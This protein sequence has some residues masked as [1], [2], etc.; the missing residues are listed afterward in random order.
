[1]TNHSRPSLSPLAGITPGY[2]RVVN[3]ER[4]AISSDAWSNLSDLAT[5]TS[6]FLYSPSTM[7][8]NN[9]IPLPPPASRAFIPS[10]Y[11]QL[12]VNSMAGINRA[13]FCSFSDHFASS[14]HN[15]SPVQLPGVSWADNF[16]SAQQAST[17]LIPSGSSSSSPLPFNILPV[18][19]RSGLSSKKTVDFLPRVHRC[20][21]CGATFASYQA[22][23]GHRGCHTRDKRKRELLNLM[24]GTSHAHA[25]DEGGSRGRK[26][27]KRKSS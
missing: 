11:S 8:N 5:Q 13:A 2:S 12:Q 21:T 22:L 27:Y 23:G 4:S 15:I 26:I 18:V 7:R 19:D 9:M 10:D 20:V 3:S 1:M 24:P 14:T 17:A 6:E 16:L 25:K